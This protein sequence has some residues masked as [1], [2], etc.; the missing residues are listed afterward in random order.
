M[1]FRP[2]WMT[3]SEDGKCRVKHR[4]SP[5]FPFMASECKK[6]NVVANRS[7]DSGHKLIKWFS[8]AITDGGYVTKLMFEVNM[9][10]IEIE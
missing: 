7:I 10:R 9:N 3:W 1:Q 6:Q 2:I 5:T 4:K 8:S